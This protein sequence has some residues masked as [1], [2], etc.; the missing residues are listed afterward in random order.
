MYA[1]VL[2]RPI[3]AMPLIVA[4]I[5]AAALVLPAALALPA[6]YGSSIGTSSPAAPAATA[7]PARG[8]DPAALELAAQQHVSLAQAE[9]RLSWQRAVPSLNTALSRQLPAAAFGG[10]W[11]ASND[12]DRVQVGLVGADSRIQATVMRAVGAAGLS[13]ATDIVPVRYSA[14]QVVA[15]DAWLSKQMGKLARAGSSPFPLDVAYRMDLNRVVLGVAGRSLT[16][17][18]QALVRRAKAQ[19]GDLVRVVSQPSGTAVGTALLGCTYPSGAAGAFPF[20]DAPLRGGI[21]IWSNTSSGLIGYCTGGFIATDN[22]TGQYY[23][24]TAG[25]C[26]ADVGTGNWYTKFASDGSQHTVGTVQRYA[27]GYGGDEAIININNPTGWMLPQGWV[28]AQ[29]QNSTTNQN[30]PIT[31]AQYSTQGARVCGTGQGTE[32]LQC[33]TVV[34]L[35]VSDDECDLPNVLTCTWV[36]NLGEA[37]F[38]AHSG[39]SGG[40]VFASN[41]AFGLVVEQH[42]YW[43]GL[44]WTPG[45]AYQGIIGAESALNANIVLANNRPSPWPTALQAVGVQGGVKL[46]WQDNS[47]NETYWIITDGTTNRYMSVSNGSTTMPVSFTWTGMGSH[48]YKCFRVNAYNAW[49]ESG[50]APMS[51]SVCAYSAT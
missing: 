38:V 22:A 21:T 26:A 34:A 30:Y 40:P 9:I 28:D 33:G 15:A 51:G 17:A 13:A 16:A 45:T 6:N 31:S 4:A 23:L 25:H 37:S 41:Q 2:K 46:T 29:G 19:Y 35:G 36:T 39:D 12:G 43:N 27:F 3:T 11:I 5:A 8:A 1:H 20:C 47:T 10:I 32:Y 24:F 18:E 48:Q 44:Y 14:S 7:N 50:P 42:E 49:G